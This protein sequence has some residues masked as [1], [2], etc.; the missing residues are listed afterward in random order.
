LFKSDA[1]E[2]LR[3]LKSPEDMTIFK[4]VDVATNL[5]IERST[6]NSGIYH[7]VSRQS[8]SGRQVFS[9]VINKNYS[10]SSPS[11]AQALFTLGVMNPE[12]KQMQK[13][14]ILITFRD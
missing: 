8:I 10:A 6:L 3:Y 1:I 9:G 7:V 13:K 11:P 12:T 5:S 2:S 14:N 4:E